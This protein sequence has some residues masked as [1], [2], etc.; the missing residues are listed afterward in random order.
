MITVHKAIQHII[1]R[2]SQAML[3][4]KQIV[5]KYTRYDK[6]SKDKKL[7]KWHIAK[8]ET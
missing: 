3:V 7:L 6:D 1:I 8:N 5:Y 2:D 4:T